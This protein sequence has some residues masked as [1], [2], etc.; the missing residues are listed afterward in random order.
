MN[1]ITTVNRCKRTQQS[2]TNNNLKSRLSTQCCNN[3]FRENRRDK[4]NNIQLMLAIRVIRL[5][6]SRL[7]L[8]RILCLLIRLRIIPNHKMILNKKILL[9]SHSH[10]LHLSHSHSHSLSQ[11]LNRRLSLYNLS[12]HN[13]NL[14]HSH[15][16]KLLQHQH[17]VQ[18]K[19][20]NLLLMIN[21]DMQMQL[22][23]KL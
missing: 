14:N 19:Q 16:Q 3:K 1:T 18:K 5:W 12:N 22:I 10:S 7:S 23:L 8:I 13:L 21:Q 11:L 15:N 2:I 6:Q 20:I 9:L 17:L 4:Q